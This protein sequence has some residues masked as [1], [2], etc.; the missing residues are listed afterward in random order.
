MDL[1]RTRFPVVKPDT[2]VEIWKLAVEQEFGLAWACESDPKTDVARL[3]E[4]RK[5]F[6]IPGAE[7]FSIFVPED[8]SKIF[9]YRKTHEALKEEQL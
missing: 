4:A 7:A 1:L 9:I 5:E 8:R 2:Y 3:Y 6:N